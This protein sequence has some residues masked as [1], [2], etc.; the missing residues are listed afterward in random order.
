MNPAPALPEQVTWTPREVAGAAGLLRHVL[1]ELGSAGSEAAVF[2]AA[3]SLVADFVAADVVAVLEGEH[4]HGGVGFGGRPP[5]RGMLRVVRDGTGHVA[6]PG[7][8]RVRARAFAV[9]G[10]AGVTLVAGWAHEP[11]D[12]DVAATLDVLTGLLGLAV[13]ALHG[14]ERERWMHLE[15][16]R[17]AAELSRLHEAVTRRE[18]VLAASLRFQREISSRQPLPDLLRRIGASASELL[19]GRAVCLVLADPRHRMDLRVVASAGAPAL[20]AQR[21]LAAAGHVVGGV[22][23]G[24]AEVSDAGGR[25]TAVAVH[26][27]GRAVGALV[28]ETTGADALD[29][30][31]RTVLLAFAEHAS[32]ALT[33]A[34]ALQAVRE[35][36]CD[37]LTRLPNRVTFLQRVEAALRA[38]GGDGAVA[39]LFVDLDGFKAVNDTMGHAAG[40]QVLAQVGRR[41][42][43]CLRGGDVAARIG[44]DEFAVLVH[45]PEP[46]HTAGRLARRIARALALPVEVG[47][48]SVQVGCST[49][50]SVATGEQGAEE[51]LR[52]ADVAMYRAK[53]AGAGAAVAF[54][55]WMLEEERLRLD[56]E[57][58]LARDGV[59]EEFELQYQPVLDLDGGAVVAV[60]ALLR[61]RHPQRGVLEPAAFLALAQ[62]CGVLARALPRLLHAAAAQ[63]AL[64]RAE[65]PALALFVDLS[66]AQL[67]D[68]ELPDLV[69]RALHAAGLE[70]GSLLLDVPASVLGWDPELLRARLGSLRATGAHLALDGF[71]AV[72]GAPL[73][74][75]RQL[76]VDVLKVDAALV[77]ALE[78]PA[79]HEAAASVGRMLELALALDLGVVA[80][81]VA[82]AVQAGL[83]RE[84]GSPA[85]QGPAL[86]APQAPAEV[87]G[88][89]AA[90]REAARG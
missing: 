27:T 78:G 6:V 41:L 22:S 57:A 59:E 44:G 39:V 14:H 25:A 45:D 28:V 10:L 67:G 15:G 40:D 90:Q 31:G 47:G 19:G 72:A 7:L 2:G 37:P 82:S 16:E 33:Q 55:P 83:L 52:C 20:A 74:P 51:L 8:G 21:A 76:P 17:D 69:R 11:V 46:L 73:A 75:L 77:A 60:E 84:L 56:L 35:A 32:M 79:A 65:V 38:A 88:L 50:V 29:E 66:P 58:D 53:Q 34:D 80:Q 62:D 4:V 86:A 48:R 26:I 71:G 5:L 68:P 36:S 12:V 13:L 85:G 9:P 24:P 64:W 23:P 49:G 30:V 70:P 1:L 81:G 42:S 87:A 54:E 63:V 61:W 3:V 43:R 89:L 18:Q